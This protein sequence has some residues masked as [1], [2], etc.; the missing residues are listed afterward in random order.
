LSSE[1][2]IEG[3]RAIPGQGTHIPLY[4]L[5]SSLFGAELAASLGLPYA[6]ASH[7]APAEMQRAIALYRSRFQPSIQLSRPYVIAGINVIAAERERDAHDQLHIVRCLFIRN[8][9]KLSHGPL[10][11][12]SDEELLRLPHAALVEQMFTHRA[13]GT[14]STVVQVLSDF[15]TKCGADEVMTV[16]HA[17]SVAQRLR[18]VELLAQAAELARPDVV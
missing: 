15:L 13:I 7:F 11:D 6:F 17:A 4:I 8:L 16:H 12:L 9:A 1:S 5:G 3:V 2:P 18:S 14:P 10:P